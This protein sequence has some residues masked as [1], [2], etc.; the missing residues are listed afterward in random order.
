MEGSVGL[1]VIISISTIILFILCMIVCLWCRKC[2]NRKRKQ[3]DH[4]NESLSK[5]QPVEL[6]VDRDVRQ[7]HKRSWD[8]KGKPP[9]YEKGSPIM[10]RKTIR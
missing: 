8:E 2:W 5:Y 7:L 4:D 6:D 10:G 1:T 9:G 3:L